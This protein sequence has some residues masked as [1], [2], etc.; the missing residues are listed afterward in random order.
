MEGQARERWAVQSKDQDYKDA[1]VIGVKNK[2]NR[3]CAKD[4]M[5]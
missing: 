1:R 5:G 4:E 2:Q 3:K